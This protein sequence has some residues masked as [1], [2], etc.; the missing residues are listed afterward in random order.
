MAIQFH[1]QSI[2]R[3]DGKNISIWGHELLVRHPHPRLL[4]PFDTELDWEIFRAAWEKI[5][6]NP[7]LCWSINLFTTT[8]CKYYHLLFHLFTSNHSKAQRTFIEL[9]ELCPYGTIEDIKNPHGLPIILD[10]FGTKFSNIDLYLT[11]R[12]VAVKFDRIFF[13]LPLETMCSLA[14]FV[15]GNCQF[16]V[17]EKIES[18]EE[19]MWAYSCGFDLYQGF[20]LDSNAQKEVGRD[21]T[22]S[23]VVR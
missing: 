13:E 18:W 14:R 19:L 12:P 8:F 3:F 2:V 5:P 4:N 23:V 7:S 1:Q 9:V 22:D 10:D 6:D 20:L 15:K 17:F 16:I 11:L 21:A